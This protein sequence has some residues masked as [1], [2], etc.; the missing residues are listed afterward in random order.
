MEPL[1]AEH[2]GGGLGV[3]VVAPHDAGPLD[4]QLAHLALG[5]GL[6]LLVHDLHLPAV[7]RNADGTHLVDVIHP[8]VDTARAGGLG[9]AVVGIVFVMGE[10]L[11]PVLDKGGRDR[12]GADVHQ[13]PL[14][15]LVV[16]Q[17]QVAPVQRGQDILTP[18]HQQPHDGAPLLGDGI[19][20]GLGAVALQQDSLAAGKQ[21]TEP[22]HLGASVIERRD[23]QEHVLMGSLVVDGL[24]PGRLQETPVAE[25]DG[26]REAGGAGG[27][28]D[29][30][31]ILVVHQHL[32]RGGGAVGSGAVVV[33]GKGGA[34]LTHKEQEALPSDRGDNVLHTAD[35]LRAEEQHIGVGQLHTVLDLLGGIAEVQGYRHRSGLEDAEVDGQP[36][37]A[38]HQQNGH[39]LALF[40][41]SAQQQVGHPVGLLIK[42]G[43]GDLPAVGCGGGGLNE[44]ILLPG[45]PLGLLNLG[46]DLY[47]GDLV[48]VELA[49]ALQQIGDRHGARSFQNRAR[50]GYFCG[51]NL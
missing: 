44:R 47:Q 28:V 35:K 18:G 11:H 32:G 25:Q 49:V 4:A 33:L 42:D 8:Q 19:K 24:H 36:L 21:G 14:A 7:S 26:L 43:P 31:V 37:Q 48:A 34:G 5:H 20:D 1:P 30:A 2:G 23:A 50:P 41:P 12:L 39:L 40:Q 29:G 27:V 10:I 17:L 22:V 15:E 46:V 3:V 13:P 45:D 6:A 51:F 9:Q 38:V 16:L